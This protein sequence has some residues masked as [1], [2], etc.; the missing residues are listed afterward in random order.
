MGV[1]KPDTYFLDKV[2][3][4]SNIGIATGKIKREKDRAPKI[5]LQCSLGHKWYTTLNILSKGHGCPKCNRGGHKT[6]TKEFKEKAYKKYGDCYS[7][8]GEYINSLTKCKIMC[9]IC[10]N[11]FMREP[12]R[13]LSGR[14]CPSCGLKRGRQ[15]I[16]SL[17]LSHDEFIDR[18]RER[19]GDK[20]RVLDMY[21]NS[22]TK[23]RVECSVCGNVFSIKPGNLLSG[24]GCPK[25]AKK[26][27]GDALRKTDAE[28]REEVYS[29]VRDEFTV[30][31]KY[32]NNKTKVMFRHNTEYPH[33]FEM[34]PTA[35]I[36]Q[37]QR[38][39]ICSKSHAERIARAWLE[40]HRVD[41]DPQHEFD[42]C[43]DRLP[44]PF[45]YYLP[46]YNIALELD[47]IQHY[48]PIEYFGG[49]QWYEYTVRHD[50]IK[51]EYCKDNGIKLIRIKYTEDTYE[52]LDNYLLEVIK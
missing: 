35:F 48:K 8:L 46:R 37:E 38:C 2:S 14:G 23:L 25:C 4:Y 22:N 31:G 44:L 41:Y 39:P 16:K 49:Q 29:L 21:V 18:V 20:Y 10:G 13:F 27:I 34:V 6:T 45:D 24:R 42:G 52:Y 30:V 11:I 3:K 7:I 36:Y 28:F 32:K 17:R 33:T 26:S 9:N 12:G 5:E 40:E 47:G 51:S 50:R 19:W 15:S 43:R 1:P